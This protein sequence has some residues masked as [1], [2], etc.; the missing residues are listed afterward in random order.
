MRCSNSR[1]K[2]SLL[3]QMSLNYLVDLMV[4]SILLKWTSLVILE[5]EQIRQVPNLVLDIVMLSVLMISNGQGGKL[6]FK[7]GHK[8]QLKELLVLAVL[9]WTFGKLTKFLKLILF[10]LAIRKVN[11]HAQAINVEMLKNV[12]WVSVIRM[13]VILML[14]VQVLRISTVLDHNS[15]LIPP[16]LSQWSL[17]SSLPMELITQIQL[18][19]VGNSFKMVKL[20][21]ILN[22]NFKVRP[23]NFHQ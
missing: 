3:M 6:M 11:S 20:L 21:N 5:R 2:N 12:I 14:S 15:K 7:D 1:I 10:I 8:V 9:N 19:F 22:H 18:M 13:A 23:N 17:N 16:D 4:L